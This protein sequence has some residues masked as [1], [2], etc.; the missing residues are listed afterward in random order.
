MNCNSCG[1]LARVCAETLEAKKEL[2]KNICIQCQIK[3]EKLDNI[4]KK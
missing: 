2:I 1:L 4:K 3:V